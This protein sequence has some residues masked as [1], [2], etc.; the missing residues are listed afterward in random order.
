[1]FDS[2]FDFSHYESWDGRSSHKI[3]RIK[4]EEC[5]LQESIEDEDVEKLTAVSFLL[6]QARCLHG[7]LEISEGAI[8]VFFSSSFSF[9]KSSSGS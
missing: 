6:S 3:W 1:M 7:L 4:L 5:G 8:G 9:S 2:R